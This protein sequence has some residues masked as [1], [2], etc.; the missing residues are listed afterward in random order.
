M[1]NI[2]LTLAIVF[3]S[4]SLMAQ[5]QRNQP[6]HNQFR[7]YVEFRQHQP[8]GFRQGEKFEKPNIQ[9]KDGKVIITMSEKQFEQMRKMRQHRQTHFMMNRHKKNDRRKFQNHPRF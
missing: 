6:V 1:K 4:F 7:D 3:G 8:E 9:R 5:N 2:F